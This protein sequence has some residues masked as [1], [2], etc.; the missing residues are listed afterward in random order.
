MEKVVVVAL[1]SVATM[2]LLALA[3]GMVDLIMLPK[4]SQPRKVPTKE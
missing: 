3:M 4:E 2:M 1:W